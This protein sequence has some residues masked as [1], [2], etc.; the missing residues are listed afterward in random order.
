M[1]EDNSGT[2]TEKERALCR[3]LA[4]GVAAAI[5]AVGD[6]KRPFRDA[7]IREVAWQLGNDGG[8]S[9]ISS[10]KEM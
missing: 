9:L 10:P 7:V 8:D 4:I 2:L 1:A 5:R 6:N 3:L